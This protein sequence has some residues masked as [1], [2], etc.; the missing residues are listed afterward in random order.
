MTLETA[1]DRV[2]HVYLDVAVGHQHGIASKPGPVDAY[3]GRIEI[4]P[5]AGLTEVLEDIPDGQRVRFRREERQP[6]LRHLVARHVHHEV[7]YIGIRAVR[8]VCAAE[9]RLTQNAH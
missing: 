1:R 5:R 6:S 7:G 9:A 8:E 2:A 3:P 4:V